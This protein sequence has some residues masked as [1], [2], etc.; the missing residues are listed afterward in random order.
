MLRRDERCFE[1]AAAR[2]QASA[3]ART[4]GLRVAY[5]ALDAPEGY[6]Y[7]LGRETGASGA[8][9]GPL[10]GQTLITWRAAANAA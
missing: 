8:V 3:E 4:S 2:R 5:G 1:K 9:S 6:S 10:S 7:T